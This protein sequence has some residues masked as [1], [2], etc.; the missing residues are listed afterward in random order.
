MVSRQFS[1]VAETHVLTL[2]LAGKQKAVLKSI[3]GIKC[4]FDEKIRKG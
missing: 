2:T 1:D 3:L 4:R